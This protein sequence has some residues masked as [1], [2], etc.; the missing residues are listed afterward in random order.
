MLPA[1]EK[2][3][4]IH[5]K[6]SLKVGGVTSKSHIHIYDV[7]TYLNALSCYNV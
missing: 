3:I 6:L 4:A 7:C 1:Y 2:S 5:G